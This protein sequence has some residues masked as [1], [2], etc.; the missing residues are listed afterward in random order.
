MGTITTSDT[1]T[2]PTRSGLKFSPQPVWQEQVT[3]TDVTPINQTHS[4]VASQCK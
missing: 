4:V 2:T 1:A 3:T